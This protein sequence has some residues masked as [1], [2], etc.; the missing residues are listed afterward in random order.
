MGIHP[1][2]DLIVVSQPVE[3]C[4]NYPLSLANHAIRAF[5]VAS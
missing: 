1:P 2:A 4:L 5:R 3:A